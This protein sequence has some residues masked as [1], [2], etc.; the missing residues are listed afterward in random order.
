MGVTYKLHHGS[1]MINGL[2]IARL[3]DWNHLFWSQNVVVL[4]SERTSV[5]KNRAVFVKQKMK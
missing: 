5:F 4:I 3:H 2:L 1:P